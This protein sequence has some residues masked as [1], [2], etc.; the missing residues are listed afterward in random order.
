[1]TDPIAAARERL[2]TLIYKTKPFL[3]GRQ[4]KELADAI[5]AAVFVLPSIAA[6]M[7]DEAEVDN[8][9][10]QG[11]DYAPLPP[12]QGAMEEAR[13]ALGIDRPRRE[14]RGRGNEAHAREANMQIGAARAA[15]EGRVGHVASAITAAEARVR[16]E[17]A[18]IADKLIRET[19]PDTIARAES[20]GAR[21][22]AAAIR[23]GGGR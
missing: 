19:L 17:C 12:A 6:P 4:A 2:A 23:A 18:K 9:L 13:A 3:T 10:R 7:S 22:I 15:L 11:A 20:D 21:H 5:L 1:M 8:T 14:Y 16:E